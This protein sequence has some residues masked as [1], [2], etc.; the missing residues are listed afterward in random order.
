MTE[1]DPL[2]NQ[3][4]SA[5]RALEPSERQI[6]AL[7]QRLAAPP[8]VSLFQEWLDLLRVS[9][10]VTGTFGVAS[11]FAILGLTPAGILPVLLLKFVG[12]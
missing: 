8:A 1:L 7:Q 12:P 11:A 2:D 5:W 9:P 10:A 4:A 3:L 6:R